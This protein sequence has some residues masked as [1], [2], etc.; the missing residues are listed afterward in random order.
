LLLSILG[1]VT[2][3][4]LFAKQAADNAVK[5]AGKVVIAMQRFDVRHRRE[6]NVTRRK[7]LMRR[8]DT[9]DECPALADFALA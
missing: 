6:R 7:R 9:E 2:V 3:I 5:L 4:W 1:R 8:S